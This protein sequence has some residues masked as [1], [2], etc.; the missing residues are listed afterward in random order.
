MRPLISRQTTA[1]GVL[2]FALLGGLLLAG[3]GEPA[4]LKFPPHDVLVLGD[5][6]AIDGVGEAL[7]KALRRQGEVSVTLGPAVDVGLATP[8]DF[9]WAAAMR[10]ALDKHRPDV[11]VLVAGRND[12]QK[13]RGLDGRPARGSGGGRLV[14]PAALYESRVRGLLTLPAA[15]KIP[16]LLVAAPPAK[17]RASKKVPWVPDALAGACRATAGCTFVG[18]AFTDPSPPVVAA[19]VVAALG[20]RLS[21]ERPPEPTPEPVA[22]RWDDDGEL[23]LPAEFSEEQLQF[24]ASAVRGRDVYYWAI[25][26]RPDKPGDT[27]PVLYLLHG[28]WGSHDDWRQHAKA[29]LKEL[30]ERYGVVIITPDGDPFGWYLDSPVEAASQLETWFVQELIP[31]VEGSSRLPVMKGAEHR[32]I[33]GLSMGGHGAFVLALRNPGAFTTA[34]S[35]SGILDITTHPTSW[36]LPD[37]LGPLDR[38]GRSRWEQHSATVLLRSV[39]EPATKLMFTVSTGDSAAYAENKALHDE[40]TRRAVPHEYAEA[41][42]GHTWDYWTSVIEDHVAF[43][44]EYLSGDGVR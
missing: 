7:D 44:A 36:E 27:F 39:P 12:R 20:T 40:L 43:H 35:M 5:G 16:I 4:E 37:R 14:D 18:D 17:A 15:S 13:P 41:P 38:G 24:H 9:D 10:G 26:P 31:H 34:S 23:I 42:G 28:A 1:A 3:A 32:A 2:L 11:L 21:W 33:A 29:D 19:A 22:E 6:L 25:V 30:A 8:K